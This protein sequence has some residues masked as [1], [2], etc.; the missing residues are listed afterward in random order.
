MD[1]Q[2]GQELLEYLIGTDL[3]INTVS[4]ATFSN[5]IRLTG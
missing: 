2:R 4:T 5:A 3:D 1:N